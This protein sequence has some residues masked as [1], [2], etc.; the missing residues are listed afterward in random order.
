M[1]RTVGFDRRAVVGAALNE[2]WARGYSGTSTERLCVATGLGRS[3]LYNTF[4]SKRGLYVECMEAYL[5]SADDWVDSV[6]ALG[7]L[8]VLDRI[9]KLFGDLIVG[10]MQRRAEGLPSGCFSVNTAVEAGDDPA[11]AEPLRLLTL[12]LRSRLGIMADHLAAGQAA[13]E[14]ANGMT[15][16]EQAEMINGAVVGIRIASR[17]GSPRASMEAIAKGALQ[18]LSSS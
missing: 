15:P 10:E 9:S 13:G 4:H 3:S 6:L 16:T 11:M 12:N 1:A 2:F 8:S 18:A 5:E 14:V 17:V 7:S